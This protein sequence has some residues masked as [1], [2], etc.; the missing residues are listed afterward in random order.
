MTSNIIESQTW[1]SFYARNL[2]ECSK[3]PSE[4]GMKYYPHFPDEETTAERLNN[5]LKVI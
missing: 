3:Q 5:L 1:V 4:T 2:N